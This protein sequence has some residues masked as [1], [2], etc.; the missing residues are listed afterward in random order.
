MIYE[1]DLFP[2][3]FPF[4]GASKTLL[5]PETATKILK[6]TIDAPFIS[7]R[8]FCVKA[9]G[10]NNLDV[11]GSLYILSHSIDQ[12]DNLLKRLKYEIPNIPSINFPLDPKVIRG[13][14]TVFCTR[15]TRLQGNLH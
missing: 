11:D 1:T 9:W 13:D 2:R 5:V 14:L 12:N 6:M 10:I 15:I 4:I 3:W 8:E 7:D